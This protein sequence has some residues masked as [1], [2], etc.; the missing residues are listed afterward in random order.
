MKKQIKI[1]GMSCN[2]CVNSVKEIL[3]VLTGAQQVE[4]SLQDKCAFLTG[5]VTDEIIKE[6]IDDIGFDVIDISVIG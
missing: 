4:V 6:A 1:E 2:H 5:E 3:E